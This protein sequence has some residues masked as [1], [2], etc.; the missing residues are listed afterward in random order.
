MGYLVDHN[1]RNSYLTE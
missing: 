1:S